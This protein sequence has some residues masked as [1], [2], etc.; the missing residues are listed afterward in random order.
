[1]RKNQYRKEID[2]TAVRAVQCAVRFQLALAKHKIQIAT[3][4]PHR[5]GS[6]S[7]LLPPGNRTFCLPASVSM[8]VDVADVMEC[9]PR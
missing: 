4:G 6:K 5:S 9:C 3:G 7:S 1:M 8:F 2:D